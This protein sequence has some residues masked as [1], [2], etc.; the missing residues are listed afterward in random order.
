MLKDNQFGETNF[1]RG[2]PGAA[3]QQLQLHGL[4]AGVRG[5][6][7]FTT[8]CYDPVAEFGN[9]VLDVPHRVILAPIV[10]LPFGREEVGELEPARRLLIG[11]WTVSA[12][13]N[14]QSGFPLQVQ[15]A[16]DARLSLGGTTTANRPNSSPA[17]IWRPPAATRIG[18]PRPITRPPPGSTRP[19]S[20]GASRHVRQR[21]PHD[22]RRAHPGAIQRRCRVH[23]E[24]PLGGSKVGQLKIEVLNLPNRPTSARCRARTRSAARTSDRPTS[25]PGSCGSRRSC[26]GSRSDGSTIEACHVKCQSIRFDVGRSGGTTPFCRASELDGA[27]GECFW[28][29]RSARRCSARTL[30]SARGTRYET[31]N[32]HHVR[33][34]PRPPCRYP[35]RPCQGRD[36]YSRPAPVSAPSATR[37]APRP[38]WIDRERLDLDQ[39]V[40]VDKRRDADGGAGGLGGVGRGVEHLAVGGVPAGDVDLVLLRRVRRPGRPGGRRRRASSQAARG[41]LGLRCS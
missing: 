14:L 34:Q 33:T 15:Q 23:Q 5:G 2:Q 35:P 9:S 19:H 38:I 37:P 41:E 30:T 6:Q 20:R 25:R 21:A 11:G 31:G 13:I 3:G 27:T 32:W 8:A 1:Y 40:S 16:A 26:S 4:D 12:A 36:R 22:H 29:L 39:P 10:E 7:D 24:L 28:P 17:R 18:W